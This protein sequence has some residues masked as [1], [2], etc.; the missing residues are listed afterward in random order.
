MSE[1]DFQRW[2]VA[3]A[4]ARGIIVSHDPDSRQQ[5]PG[6]PDLML[7]GTRLVFVEVKAP[8]GVLRDEQREWH[9]RLTMAGQECYIVAPGD[10]ADIERLLDGLAVPGY[11]A[12]PAPCSGAQR[13]GRREQGQSV[14]GAISGPTQSRTS[15]LIG[16]AHKLRLSVDTISAAAAVGPAA[17][18]ALI[19]D[20]RRRVAVR[21]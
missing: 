17:L 5:T 12:T 3:E 21:G 20:E 14:P 19:E 6:E 13:A 8:K 15:Q 2:I 7:L 1:A 9:N 11:S 10:E 4:A 16:E 18:A